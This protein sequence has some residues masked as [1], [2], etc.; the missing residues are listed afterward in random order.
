M[1]VSEAGLKLNQMA[2]DYFVPS[3]G[4]S[5]AIVNQGQIEVTIQS[6]TR[7]MVTKK[8][9]SLKLIQRLSPLSTSQD[10]DWLLDFLQK[11][12][13]T[14]QVEW[15]EHLKGTEGVSEEVLK[16]AKEALKTHVEQCICDYAQ[17]LRQ[18][19]ERYPGE[20][21]FLMRTWEREFKH[22]GNL[23]KTLAKLDYKK[24]V[25]KTK[26]GRSLLL[27]SSLG[28]VEFQT[29][30]SEST[31]VVKE[32]SEC[33]LLQATLKQFPVVASLIW[34]LEQ[35]IP[36][37]EQLRTDILDE[38]GF[39]HKMKKYQSVYSCRTEFLKRFNLTLDVN[40][41]L[42]F[43]DEQPLMVALNT[44]PESL[45]LSEFEKELVTLVQRL[46]Q[47]V[48]TTFERKVSE[49]ERV[50]KEPATGFILKV[51]EDSPKKGITTYIDILKGEKS[52][53]IKENGYD[54]LKSYGSL[55]DWTKVKIRSEIVALS[56]QG[57][58]NHETFKASFGR[59][60]G[61]VVS[62]KGKELLDYVSSSEAT[63][64]ASNPYPLMTNWHLFEEALVNF[65]LTHHFKGLLLAFAQNGKLL[66]SELPQVIPF[67]TQ[68]RKWYRQDDPFLTQALATLIPDQGKDFIAMNAQ[69]ETGKTKEILLA[70]CETMER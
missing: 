26:K 3:L 62:K 29:S 11:S 4:L 50:G 32:K 67:V 14:A 43:F 5:F 38:F 61:Y 23:L 39:N 65:D 54:R 22:Q 49:L 68:Y 59:Y 35:L 45:W 46:R 69:F 66:L 53:K 40:K 33:L 42:F 30:Q 17:P 41:R 24:T 12:P 10:L 48:E 25:R 21:D 31:F 51:V 15:T 34:L 55:L 1:K 70:I 58:L 47:E 6:L 37:A 52:S 19:I 36:Q 44:L 16:A 18:L 27:E 9:D 64:T 2:N 28:V 20:V 57:Y 63:K 8:A 56:E 7:R 60:E 13:S